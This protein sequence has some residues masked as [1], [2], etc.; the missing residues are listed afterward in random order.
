MSI[1]ERINALRAE[2]QEKNPFGEKVSI[3]LATKMRTVEEINEAILAGVDA[4]AE[5]K[6]QEFREKTDLLLPC[7]QHFIGHLQTNKVKYLVGKITLFHS[8]DRDELA[9]KIA[10]IS[11]KKGVVSDVLMQVNIGNEESKGGYPF[12]EAKECF[13]R[14]LAVAGLRV[15]GVMAILP[16][17]ENREYLAE[18]ADKMRELFEWCKTKSENVD[19]LSMG[20]SGDYALCVER[21]SNMIRVGSTVF[22]AR[23]YLK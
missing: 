14:L 13:L 15:R 22:G 12:E 9:N 18:L 19:Y 4:V 16:E 17:S 6:A 11:L 2:L 23:E 10:E 8:C 1:A 5:N 7:E 20:M 3:V 21:G